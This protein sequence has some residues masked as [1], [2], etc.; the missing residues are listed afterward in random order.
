MSGSEIR[1]GRLFQAASGRSFMVAL[2]RTLS[3]GPEEYAEN[4]DALIAS[5]VAAGAD[6]MLLSPGLIRR[7]GHRV[8]FRGGPA[9]VARIDF[10]F[11][12]ESTQGSGEEFRLIC[13]VEEAVALGADA[14]VVFLTTAVHN[15]RVFADNAA[16]VGTV[17]ERCRR[18]GVPLVV[19]AVPWG[20]A[21]PDPRDPELVAQSARIAVELGADVVKTENLDDPEAMRHVIA[22]CAVPVLLLGGPKLPLPELL[23]RTER[24]LE[25]GARGV[26][27]GRNSWQRPD[28]SEAMEALRSLVHGGRSDQ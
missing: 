14:V 4:S 8:S 9:L 1:T 15:R 12:Y 28:A 16:A 11:M 26:V 6:A 27:F 10:P 25:C 22:S 19:E 3:V 5:V 24:G 23:A 7:H 13:G 2:D 20:A 21:S 18:L 17:A